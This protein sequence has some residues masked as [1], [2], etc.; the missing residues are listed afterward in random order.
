MG[1]YVAFAF[2]RKYASRVCALILADTR[3][4]PDSPEGKKG[5]DDSI[6]LARSNGAA[7]VAEKM[8]PKM[9]TAQTIA[10]DA[11]VANAARTLM[12]RQP[13]EGVIAVLPPLTVADFLLSSSEEVI[14]TRSGVI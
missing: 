4:L 1:G 3:A 7:A 10:E 8:F 12:S 11:D 14:Y 13:A 5:R 2:Y 9:L 6:G